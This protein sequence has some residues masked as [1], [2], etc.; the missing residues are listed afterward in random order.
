MP[1]LKQNHF[2]FKQTLNLFS[3]FVLLF[4]VAFP[5]YAQKRTCDH[6]KKPKLKVNINLEIPEATYD[7]SKST[8]E[9]TDDQFEN[10]VEWIQKQ[11]IRSVGIAEHLGQYVTIRGLASGGYAYAMNYK[12]Q[13]KHVDKYGVYYCPYLTE[14]NIDL[15]Y[16]TKIFIA[17]EIPKNTCEFNEVMKHEWKHHTANV[18]A[19]KT[20][21]DRLKKDLPTIAREIELQHGYVDRSLVD[22]TFEKIKTSVRDMIEVYYDSIW[23]DSRSRN[24]L[25]DTQEEYQRVDSAIDLC[26]KEK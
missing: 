17:S 3:V 12:M 1:D 23:K 22:P 20:Y 8:E 4:F 26:E 11:G 16:V 2:T 5:S 10:T 6:I 9:L 25:I 21:S 19:I 13:A 18:V 14:V 24:A 7:Y 15:F